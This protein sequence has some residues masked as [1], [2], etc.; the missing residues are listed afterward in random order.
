MS[1]SLWSFVG[2]KFD[3][4]LPRMTAVFVKERASST[5]FAYPTGDNRTGYFFDFSNKTY[6]DLPPKFR[7]DFAAYVMPGH[8]EDF[9][10]NRALFKEQIYYPSMFERQVEYTNLALKGTETF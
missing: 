9:H 7:F 4:T 3:N 10:E 2:E 6:Y 8:A 1:E 5:S